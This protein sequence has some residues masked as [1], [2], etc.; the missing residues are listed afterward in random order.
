MCE[1][2]GDMIMIDRLADFFPENHWAWNG[3]E[4]VTLDDITKAIANA[5]S[6]ENQPYGNAQK[7]ID[8]DVKPTEWH[9][10]RIIYFINHQDEIRDIEVDNVCNGGYICPI[11]VIIDGNHRF[12]AAMWLHKK[13]K[14]DKVYCQYGGRTDLLDYLTGDSD[15]LPTE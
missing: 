11:P 6:E 10:G 7:P 1:Y 13:G 8:I 14:M 9:I 4:T 15:E 3:E 12:I 5:H 2:N